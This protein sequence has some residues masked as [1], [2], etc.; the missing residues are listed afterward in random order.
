VSFWYSS[1][2]AAQQDMPDPAVQIGELSVLP[3]DRENKA[4]PLCLERWVSPPHQTLDS[5]TLQVWQEHES[6]KTGL[7]FSVQ[8]KQ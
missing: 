8:Y 5:E 1:P 3:W 2:R 7:S 4:N 6:Y